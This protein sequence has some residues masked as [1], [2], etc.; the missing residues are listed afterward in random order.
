MIKRKALKTIKLCFI[1]N[2][3]KL[4]KVSKTSLNFNRNQNVV[5]LT[6]AFLR[7][8]TLKYF[9]LTKNLLMESKV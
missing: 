9:F 1:Q 2:G 8:D 4:I 3:I 7:T 5:I 6:C